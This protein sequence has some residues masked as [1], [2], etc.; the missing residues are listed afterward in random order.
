[1]VWSW[2]L[3][4]FRAL[5]IAVHI[6][7]IFE[8]KY[9]I[10]PPNAIFCTFAM[11]FFFS[12]HLINFIKVFVMVL[13]LLILKIA[14]SA[15]LLTSAKK[16]CSRQQI[17]LSCIFTSQAILSI[18]ILAD[19]AKFLVE[20]CWSAVLISEFTAYPKAFSLVLL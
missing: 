1:M 16:N 15:K 17:F 13:C 5:F 6:T 11:F 14:N 19:S 20:N 3:H 9:S 4:T 7:F 2:N 18:F 12:A 8:I 10:W